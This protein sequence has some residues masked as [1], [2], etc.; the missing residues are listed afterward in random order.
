MANAARLGDSRTIEACLAELP[1][2]APVCIRDKYGWTALHYAAQGAKFEACK[3]LLN[4]RGD[5]NT[6][7][8]DFSTPIMLAVEEGNISVAELLL[9]HGARTRSK[10]E[11]G[12][13][14]LDR[15]APSLLPE[16]KA[17]V[18]QYM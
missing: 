14:V 7:L 12:F 3:L 6:E 13:T 18:Q 15:C 11:A 10:D 2:G 17:L 8:P 9:Q 5:A 1:D 4:A 16:F